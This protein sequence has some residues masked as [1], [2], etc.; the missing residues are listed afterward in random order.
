MT[1]II[2]V[3]ETFKRIPIEKNIFAKGYTPNWSENL[4]R[5]K[6]VHKSNVCY[7][8]ITSI[9]PSYPNPDRSFHT[10]ELNLVFMQ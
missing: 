4:Y 10:D 6:S 5:I 9:N 2:T 8:Y 1:H 3:F 7:Y